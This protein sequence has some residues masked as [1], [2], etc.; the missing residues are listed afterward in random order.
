MKLKSIATVT[1]RHILYFHNKMNLNESIRLDN[2]A[3]FDIAHLHKNYLSSDETNVLTY[4][5]LTNAC[6]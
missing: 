1:S 4:A 5:N 2:S 6:E 3:L